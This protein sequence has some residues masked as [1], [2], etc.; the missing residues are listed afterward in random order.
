[1]N[2]QDW[3]G[4]HL[5]KDI[6]TPGNKVYSESTCAFVYPATNLFMNKNEA[7]GSNLPTGVH[8]RKK[9]K[10]F[11]AQCSN[12]FKKTDVFLGYFGSAEEASEAYLD[13]KHSLAVLIS[14]LESDHRVINALMTRY[15]KR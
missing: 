10:K 15:A 11:L 9:D 3:Q 12:P 1:M 4:K 5:D 8:W 2:K 6:I 13:Y 7:M 14:S